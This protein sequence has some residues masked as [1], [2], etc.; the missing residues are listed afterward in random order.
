[1]AFSRDDLVAYEAAP[2]T[3]VEI[4]N[5]ITVAGQAAVKEPPPAAKP[6]AT[7]AAD[8]T[9]AQD[10]ASSAST[11]TD[12]ADTVGDESSGDDDA[13]SPSADTDA[14]GGTD[15]D[16]AV[17]APAATAAKG[18]ARARIEELVDERNAYK[19]F[20]KYAQEE[21]QRLKAELEALKGGEKPADA[22]A[23]PADA[24]PDAA[25]DSDPPPTLEDPEI[26][27]DPVKLQL[28]NAK[29]MKRQIAA[30]VKAEVAAGKATDT[31]AAARAA[32]ESRAN[33]FAVEH[34]DFATVIGNPKLPQ[35][36]PAARNVIG[37]SENGPAILYEIAKDVGLATRIAKMTPEMQVFKIGEIAAKVTA[38]V[39]AATATKPADATP[40]VQTPPRKPKTLTQAPPP[41]TKVPAGNQNQE[42][43]LSDSSL[44][45]DEFVKRDRAEKAAMRDAKR[46]M[47]LGR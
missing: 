21:N 26:Q 20:G 45:M 44:S 12:T 32:F 6:D 18:S 8:E 5:A 22:A 14:S 35:L 27:F 16:D 23:K 33:T 47:R 13:G 30:G 17:V 19:N 40:S 34:K 24:A 43:P 28:A 11:D 7:P 9:L 38:P 29:W 31:V 46:K 25:V 41:P 4:P 1:M 37:H 39:A 3:M 2:Q 15:A 36:H 42:V 10:D